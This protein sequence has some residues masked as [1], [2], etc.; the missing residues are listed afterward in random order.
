[1]DHDPPESGFIGPATDPANVAGVRVAHLVGVGV[2]GYKA[3]PVGWN[4]IREVYISK[5]QRTPRLVDCLR[6]TCTAKI[7]WVAW[8]ALLFDAADGTTLGVWRVTH[9]SG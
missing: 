6:G 5:D 8:I 3:L 7:T 1:M 9:S 4:P 2:A